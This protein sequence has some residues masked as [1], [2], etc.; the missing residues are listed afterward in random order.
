MLQQNLFALDNCSEK[1]FLPFHPK[2]TKVLHLGKSRLFGRK[3]CAEN[4]RPETIE[5]GITEV[6]LGVTF[7]HELKWRNELARR[8][9]QEIFHQLN[10]EPIQIPLRILGK[11][12]P[13]ICNASV[14]SWKQKID[15]NYRK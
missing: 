9:N 13:R 2:K 5:E 12:S 1:L 3:Y 7:D 10:C 4:E 15:Q 8:P 11:A 6:D 14:E